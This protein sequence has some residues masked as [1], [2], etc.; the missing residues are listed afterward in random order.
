ML[1]KQLIVEKIALVKEYGIVC[2]VKI[3]EVNIYSIM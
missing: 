2:C 3:H 1:W